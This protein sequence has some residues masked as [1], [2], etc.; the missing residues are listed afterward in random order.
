VSG[1]L[2]ERAGTARM[3]VNVSLGAKQVRIQRKR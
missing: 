3:A 2:S 1:I